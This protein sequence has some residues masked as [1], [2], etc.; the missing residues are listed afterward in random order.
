MEWG[1]NTA[2]AWRGCNPD[3]SLDTTCTAGVDGFIMSLGLQGDG[4]L[5]LGGFFG[6]VNGYARTSLS[7]LNANAAASLDTAF[8]PIVT[9]QD[10]SVSTL[11]SVGPLPNSQI[12]VA[13]DFYNVNGNA[14][15]TIASRLNG[16]GSLDAAFNV[17]ITLP[18][19][20][21]SLTPGG[22]KVA[23]VGDKYVVSGFLG[24]PYYGTGF[25][26]RLTSTG[27]LDSTFGPS[28]PSTPVPN[29]N[30]MTGIMDMFL[31]P[32]GRIMVS[33]SLGSLYDGSSNPPMLNSIARFTA[34]GFL[35]NTFT[36]NPGPAGVMS[37]YIDS[38]ALQPNGKI[39]IGGMFTSYDS[40]PRINIARIN[41][42]GSLDPTFDPG[43]GAGPSSW[44]VASILR[45][46]SGKALLGG[47]FSTYNGTPEGGLARIFAGPANFN[48]GN[49]LLLL[50]D[51]RPQAWVWIGKG[52][53]AN[54]RR[55]LAPRFVAAAWR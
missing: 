32:D 7:R 50:G 47:N 39:L 8:N 13:G 49:L 1:A 53:G 34:D 25:L 16:D 42:N 6:E 35:D 54:G 36:A 44:E 43:T 12:M 11:Y 14:N 19:P 24:D 30:L 46:S 48:P 27:A 29:V 10:G 41:P 55:P 45:L 4:K 5:L 51:Y 20:G 9:R 23:P 18:N 15:R 21:G 28:A 37:T 52:R 2:T 38:M 26:I 17:Q 3:G 40:T 31:Q 33:G 22:F